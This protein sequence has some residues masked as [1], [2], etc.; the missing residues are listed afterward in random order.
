MPPGDGPSPSGAERYASLRQFTTLAP[1]VDLLDK[2]TR[3]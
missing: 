1:G 2:S 3:W